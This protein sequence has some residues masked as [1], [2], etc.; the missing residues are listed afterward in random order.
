M[1]VDDLDFGFQ[2]KQLHDFQVFTNDFINKVRERGTLEKWSY[3]E[4][5]YYRKHDLFIFRERTLSIR[6]CPIYRGWNDVVIKFNIKGVQFKNYGQ[7]KEWIFELFGCYSELIWFDAYIYRLDLCF[8][9]MDFNSKRI[10]A[11]SLRV[12]SQRKTRKCYGPIYES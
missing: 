3:D 10:K 11:R 4:K 9:T 2:T 1:A 6:H 5:K 12:G 8:E 7:L